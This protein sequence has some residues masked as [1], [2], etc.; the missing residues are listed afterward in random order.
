MVK[1]TL[2]ATDGLAIWACAAFV[3][4]FTVFLVRFIWLFWMNKNF[5]DKMSHLP[6]EDD[7]KKGDQ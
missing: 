7:D 4:F 1:E 6:F 2:R 3:L 5:I